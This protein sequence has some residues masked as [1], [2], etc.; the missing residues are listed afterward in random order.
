MEHRPWHGWDDKDRPLNRSQRHERRQRRDS[1]AQ[2]P[3]LV[4]ARAFPNRRWH[5]SCSR[6]RCI[7]SHRISSLSMA[8]SARRTPILAIPEISPSASHPSHRA[9]QR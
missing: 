9:S 2:T 8:V 3:I 5:D 4:T 7:D 1:P 6:R